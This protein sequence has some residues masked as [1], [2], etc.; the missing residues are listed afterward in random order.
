VEKV[1]E[2]ALV[3]K[4]TNVKPKGLAAL[5]LWLLLGLLIPTIPFGG[6]IFAWIPAMLLF[7]LPYLYEKNMPVSFV[8]DDYKLHGYGWGGK[9]QWSIPWEDI[10]SLYVI[11][12]Y[13]SG[14]SWAAPKNLGL[15]L[16]RYDNFRASVASKETGR[17]QKFIEKY[18]TSNFMLK[19]SRICSKSELFIAYSILDRP[20]QEFAELLQ[21]YIYMSD[22][23][24]SS[25]E[26]SLK[27]DNQNSIC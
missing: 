16:K 14:F 23:R 10:E 25:L 3:I 12:I 13:S 21:A 26:S 19:F 15:R 18:A 6:I 20:T 5:A 9:E 22:E 17:F 2:N 7:V 24:V 27:G 4:P 11:Q 1:N 8:L